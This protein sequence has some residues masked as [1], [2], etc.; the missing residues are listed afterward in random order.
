MEGSATSRRWE[1]SLVNVAFC[2]GIVVFHCMSHPITHLDK[3]SWQFALAMVCQR[4]TC[5]GVPGFFFLS[6]LK[7][8]LPSPRQ[9]TLGQYYLS[10]FRRLIPPYLLAAALS[11]FPFVLTGSY[12][13]S[14]KNFALLTIR[15]SLSA[16]FYYVV[17]LLQFILLAPLFRT[18]V[19]RYSPAVL[20]PI[21]LLITR[22]ST[23]FSGAAGL[24][25]PD[26]L[27]ALYSGHQFTDALFYYLA[28]CFAGARYEAF[29]AL[30]EKHRSLIFPLFA[31]SAPAAIA[32]SVVNS[33]GRGSP[34][35]LESLNILF[36]ISY[37][38]ALYS[39]AVRLAPRMNGPAA[40]LLGALDRASYLI[41]LYHCLA[42][43]L[44]DAAASRLGLAREAPLL[45]LRLLIVL[46][47]AIG[48][49]VLWQKLRARP[50]PA[51]K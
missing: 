19:Q 51:Q 42:I 40:R 43:T 14:L 32:A 6:G 47:A 24:P 10:R 28:G 4:L 36:Y 26:W 11:Y 37:T 35:Y 12:P 1:L 38:L 5:I 44:F 25:A 50:V 39:L 8:T 34:P 27:A 31:L 18:L 2:L 16:Q 46:S 30:L 22:L 45:L 13:F 3:L 15:G 21:A 7:F 23:E 9:R 48:G 20:L 49:S 29:L 33:S 41:Y 17:V